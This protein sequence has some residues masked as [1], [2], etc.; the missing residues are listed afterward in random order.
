MTLKDLITQLRDLVKDKELIHMTYSIAPYLDTF[1][2][3]I[4]R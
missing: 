1:R 2:F 3:P 4:R